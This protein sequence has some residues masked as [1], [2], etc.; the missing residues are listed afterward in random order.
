[1]RDSLLWVYEGQTQ[2]WGNVL[3]AR[4]GLWS[5]AQALD[6]LAM[7]AATYSE[8]RAGRSWRPLEDTTHQPII[9]A[10]HKQAWRTWQRAEDYYNEGLLMWLEADGLI[11]KRSAK[12]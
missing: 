8:G 5:K 12:L 7:D 2:Y 4:S 6:A 1:M 9:S 3:A 11:R 10:R